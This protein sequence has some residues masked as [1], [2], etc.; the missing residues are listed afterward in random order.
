MVIDLKVSI[1][2]TRV[3]PSTGKAVGATPSARRSSLDSHERHEPAGDPGR[4]PVG[5]YFSALKPYFSRIFFPSADDT[6]STKDR[7]PS[8][9]RAP[10]T[11]AIG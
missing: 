10:F 9:F 2:G 6:K 8:A 7:A 11:T 5:I 3:V 4:E 1:K